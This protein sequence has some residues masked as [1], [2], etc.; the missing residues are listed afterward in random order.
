MWSTKWHPYAAELKMELR[1][2]SKKDSL[3]DLAQE[4]K[5]KTKNTGICLESFNC[6]TAMIITSWKAAKFHQCCNFWDSDNQ[7][8]MAASTND[9]SFKTICVIT[10]SIKIKYLDSPP[11]L[12]NTIWP[13]IKS[14]SP[15]WQFLRSPKM[16]CCTDSQSGLLPL[17][18]WHSQILPEVDIKLPYHLE[19]VQGHLEESTYE[20]L[21]LHKKFN[22]NSH[23]QNI[24]FVSI[25]S[26]LEEGLPPMD[27]LMGSPMVDRS[28]TKRQS[29]SWR[30]RLIE[31]SML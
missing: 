4:N 15:E 18:G 23:R 21:Y 5:D 25:R 14:L 31:H 9:S 12:W 8:I 16:P 1:S 10:V 6:Q 29:K 7:W 24:Y 13:F 27:S 22:S 3:H 2:H 19:K 26:D 20:K 17:L 11:S 30:Q 28:T